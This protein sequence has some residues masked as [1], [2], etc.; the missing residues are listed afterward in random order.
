MLDLPEYAKSVPLLLDSTGV[1]RVGDT[2]VTLDTVVEAFKLGATAEGIVEQF[3]ALSLADIYSTIGF[4]L[5]NTTEIDAFLE[6]RRRQAASSRESYEG[7][8]LSGYRERLLARRAH[9]SGR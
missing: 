3:P 6:E 2:R 8:S 4:Y 1:V 7:N 5:R 9:L